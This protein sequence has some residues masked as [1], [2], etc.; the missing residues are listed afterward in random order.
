MRGL[1][2]GEGE[3]EGEEGGVSAK[4]RTYR[5]FIEETILSP[6]VLKYRNNMV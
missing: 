3:G 5:T 6:R 4:A 1:V 2:E